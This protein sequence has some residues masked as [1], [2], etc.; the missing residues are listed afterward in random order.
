MP[1]SRFNLSITG[2][3]ISAS[4]VTGCASNKAPGVGPSHNFQV[5]VETAGREV[6]S[7]APL[8]HH[9]Y[10]DESQLTRLETGFLNLNTLPLKL[11]IDGKGKVAGVRVQ[12]GASQSVLQLLGLRLNDR[13]TGVSGRPIERISDLTALPAGLRSAN[14]GSLTLERAGESHKI[15]FYIGEPN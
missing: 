14:T 7:F 10:L 1:T 8:V 6:S 5:S 12:Q 3:V 13:L 2:F 4:L 11:D 15:Y 9:L